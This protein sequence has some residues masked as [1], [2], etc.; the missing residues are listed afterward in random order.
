MFYFQ[1]IMSQKWFTEKEEKKL[2]LYIKPYRN[3]MMGPY[4]YNL[5]ACMYFFSNFQRNYFLDGFASNVKPEYNEQYYWN[6]YIFQK[7]QPRFFDD[8][9]SHLALLSI[10]IWWR[11]DWSIQ[12]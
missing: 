1:F 12:K 4:T 7:T 6:F 3:I 2:I 10:Q 11:D 9:A 5:G 8:K